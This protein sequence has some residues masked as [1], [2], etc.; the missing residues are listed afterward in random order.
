MC[1]RDRFYPEYRYDKAVSYMENRNYDNALQVF[2]SLG[3]YKD[4]SKKLLETKYALS[5]IHI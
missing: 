5:L 1:I 2:E 3:D 4:S